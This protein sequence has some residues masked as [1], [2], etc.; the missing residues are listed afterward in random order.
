MNSDRWVRKRA[1]VFCG[2]KSFCSLANTVGMKSKHGSYVQI[3]SSA[4]LIVQLAFRVRC[5][6]LPF[7]KLAINPV[8]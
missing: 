5:V 2:F 6:H 7:E 4:A 3:H 8:A 1:I